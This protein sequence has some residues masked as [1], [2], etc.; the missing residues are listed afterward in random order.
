[1]ERQP[2]LWGWW[3][4]QQEAD[5][6]R[7]LLAG[8][9][10]DADGLVVAPDFALAVRGGPENCGV[11]ETETV[12]VACYG[13]FRWDD[14]EAGGLARQNPARAIGAAYERHGADFVSR[15]KG[16]WAIAVVDRRE[17]G[18]VLLLNDRMGVE[19]LCY[20]PLDGGGLVFASGAEAVAAYPDVAADLDYQAVHNFLYYTRVPAPRT[21]FKH[22]RKFSMATRL[23][24]TRRDVRTD[25]YWRVPYEEAPAPFARL[26]DELMVRLEASVGD[27]AEPTAGRPI[28]AFLSGGLDSSTVSGLLARAGHAP[29]LLNVGFDLEAYNESAFAEQAARHFERPLTALR[30]QARE[31]PRLTQ[32]L[33]DIYDEPYANSSAVASLYAAECAAE[34]GLTCLFAGDGGDEI[35]AG[36]ERYRQQAIFE[37]YFRL[38]KLLRRM[39]ETR[40]LQS[41]GAKAFPLLGKVGK[42]AARANIRLPDRL[43]SYNYYE[44]KRLDTIYA[45]ELA[46][47]VDADE[48]K[49]ILRRHYLDAAPATSALNRMMHVDLRTTLVD[50]D[51][52]KVTKTCRARG[53]SV[54]FPILTEEV[55]EFAAR[56]PS[57]EK[58]NLFRLR[59]FYKRAMKQFLPESTL[60][61][62]KHG[63]GLPFGVWLIREPEV[64]GFVQDH[65]SDLRDR[66]LF[67]PEFVEQAR[68]QPTPGQE[69]YYG[70]VVWVLLMLE[71]W[72]SKQAQGNALSRTEG[73]RLSAGQPA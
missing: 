41:D 50:D 38:P 29:D 35:F 8:M 42:F 56:V 49:E 2:Q 55:V 64:R 17:A 32:S 18:S 46:R 5:A 26:R 11:W 10:G 52:R 40:L 67:Q 31:L 4:R 65:L 23:R 21:V 15:L 16:T 13:F 36:N 53:L 39:L 6:A 44:A 9:G 54:R 62:S 14:D 72:L 58:L 57:R 71:L 33:A 27:L 1:M 68:R 3:A 28:G 37:L 61:K 24:A 69:R 48:P 45:P 51:L 30:L 19:N 34:R 20:A 70:E 63:F 7:Q 43:E 47:V 59:H 12:A 60:T 73:S 25:T 22:V 66:G